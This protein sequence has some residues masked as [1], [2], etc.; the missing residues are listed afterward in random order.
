MLFPDE[1]CPLCKE[2]GPMNEADRDQL[3]ADVE[4]YCREIHDTEELCYVEHKFN[5]QVI[6]L[7]KKYN[8]LGMPVPKEYGG[9]G[10][11]TV[12]YARALARIN[13]EG[14][15]VRTFFSGHTRSEERRVGKECRSR[16]SPYH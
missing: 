8:L 6:P 12:T 15:G 1:K 11:D 14:T 13:Q 3:L 2:R 9:R 16:W 5:D 4:A 10:A 7:A